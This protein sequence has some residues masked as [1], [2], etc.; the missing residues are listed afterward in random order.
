MFYNNIVI[1]LRTWIFI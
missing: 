1:T